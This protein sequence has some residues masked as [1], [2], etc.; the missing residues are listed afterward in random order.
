MGRAAPGQPVSN[1]RENGAFHVCHGVG[2]PEFQSALGKGL[3]ISLGR[4]QGLFSSN[5]QSARSEGLLYV[6]DVSG[7][8]IL[9]VSIGIS[10]RCCRRLE[11]GRFFCRARPRVTQSLHGPLYFPIDRVAGGSLYP[12]SR[13]FLSPARVAHTERRPT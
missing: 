13:H 9:C 3:R 8:G 10:Y 5:T 7:R 4:Q 12:R 11:G 2:R 1:E 6:V